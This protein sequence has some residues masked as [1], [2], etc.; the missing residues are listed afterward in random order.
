MKEIESVVLLAEKTSFQS[1]LEAELSKKFIVRHFGKSDIS[2]VAFSNFIS[3]LT[4][5]RPCCVINLLSSDGGLKKDDF[6]PYIQRALIGTEALY[7]EVSPFNCGESS[8]KL[9]QKLYSSLVRT[10]FVELGLVHSFRTKNLITDFLDKVKDRRR[11]T[12]KEESN[13]PLISERMAAKYLC[14]FLNKAFLKQDLSGT[15]QLCENGFPHLSEVFEEALKTAS[16][17]AP[18]NY[19]AKL[20]FTPE[21]P[22]SEPYSFDNT[23][24]QMDSELILGDWRDGVIETTSGWV[25][26][27]V[28]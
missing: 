15:Y 10:V 16:V 5:L 17:I 28:N 1:Y 2:E 21:V 18:D 14:L 11:I 22:S 19:K 23:K 26:E 9:H 27:H 7:L 13:L 20:V 3:V 8:G 12:L 25:S 4:L 24:F 6:G